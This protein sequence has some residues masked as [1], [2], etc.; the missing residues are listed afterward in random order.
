MDTRIADLEKSGVK[1][2]KVSLL[3]TASEKKPADLT[4]ADYAHDH[5]KFYEQRA[6]AAYNTAWNAANIVKQAHEG[7]G[8]IISH[9]ETVDDAGELRGEERERAT[10]PKR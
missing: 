10:T 3:D 1:D 9:H 6:E 2:L 5:S 8:P 4:T 7:V